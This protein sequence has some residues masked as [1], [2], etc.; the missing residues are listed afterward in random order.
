[1]Q[2]F[3]RKKESKNW[4][5]LN[6]R[7]AFF[8]VVHCISKYFS[9]QHVRACWVMKLKTKV[10]SKWRVKKIIQYIH[11]K[12]NWRWKDRE[13]SN[14]T[15]SLIRSVKWFFAAYFFSMLERERGLL[16]LFRTDDIDI[17][18]L[19]TGLTVDREKN[20][21]SFRILF[22]K[23]II[24]S[25]EKNILFWRCAINSKQLNNNNKIK[26]FVIP[27]RFLDEIHLRIKVFETNHEKTF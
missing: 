3:S 6:V 20:W 21:K 22:P 19:E 18:C 12:P 10:R 14:F 25:W 7:V 26:F 13:K 5:N 11:T 24:I 16:W 27:F 8:Y 15:I 17:N 23:N 4:A 9:R 1:M 2:F